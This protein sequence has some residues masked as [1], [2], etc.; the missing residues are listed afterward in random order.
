L[1]EIPHA[2]AGDLHRQITG[3]YN[4]IDSAVDP[5]EIFRVRDIVKNWSFENQFKFGIKVVEDYGGVDYL[6]D[7]IKILYNALVK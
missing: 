1:I 2:Q 3:Y 7:E 6:S 5:T 4:S